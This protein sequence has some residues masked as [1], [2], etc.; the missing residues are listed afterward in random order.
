MH[1]LIYTNNIITLHGI[2]YAYEQVEK[3]DDICVHIYMGGQVIA[4]L[5]GETSI[6]GNSMQTADDIINYLNNNNG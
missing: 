5:G 3:I 2:D 6:N 4:F 1:E